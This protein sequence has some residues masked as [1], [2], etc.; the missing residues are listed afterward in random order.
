[1]KRLALAL[2]VAVASSVSVSS[3]ASAASLP[4]AAPCQFVL[5]F[6]A[7]R[8]AVPRVGECRDNQAFAANGDAQQQTSGGL[9]V[10]RKADNWTAFTDG[11]RTWV[12]GPHGIQE[13]LNSQRFPWEG[14]ESGFGG[15]T[16]E[17]TA[18]KAG[19]GGVAVRLAPGRAGV[20]C[21]SVDI[22]G[23]AA[24]TDPATG[25]C[26]G[27]DPRAAGGYDGGLSYYNGG[28]FFF[29][30]TVSPMR[31]VAPFGQLVASWN[32]STP[33]GTWIET[34]V[35]VQEGGTWTHWYALPVWASDTGTIHRHS[36]DG[37]A[38]A[39]GSVQTDTFLTRPGQTASAYQVEVTLFS[40]SPNDS[41]AVRLIHADTAAGGPDPIALPADK[42]A[43]GVDLPVPQRSQMLPAYS[44]LGFGGG[45]EVWCSP[46]STSM[47]MAY[48]GQV[49]HQPSLAEAVPA[50]AAATYDYTYQG[51]GD[52]P[53]NVAYAASSG[54]AGFVTRMRSLSQVE[55]WIKAGVP[56]V[57]SIAFHQ[58]ELAG[59]PVANS[60]GHLIVIRGF[61][62]AGN[63]IA[64]D[65]A[66]G[67]DAGGRI[68][69]D[70]VQLERV[71]QRGSAGAA[72]V[73][74][75]RGWQT[76]PLTA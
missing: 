8:D 12:N 40:V 61:T 62:T 76:P 28:S 63:V 10:W 18:A 52:W 37:Q 55:P 45:G 31:A 39:G 24:S 19:S 4:A 21:R 56:I 30:S 27:T 72:Y 26:A 57:V 5:G 68:V 1:M 11:F 33:P 41:P 75:P 65:P 53:F 15:W 9:L 32:A 54:L 17:G 48:W 69:Y 29:G 47:V 59:E 20:T 23:G 16:F 49:L 44:G 7:L 51:T 71:W 36:V 60:T 70:R 50:A 2:V 14:D 43:W 67:T 66:A 64:N 35:R 13:R 22:D 38:D 42:A 6:K 3:A 58:G 34:H 46:T 74:Y 25:L 73:I